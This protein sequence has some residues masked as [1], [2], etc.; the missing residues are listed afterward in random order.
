MPGHMLCRLIDAAAA[1]ARQH[2]AQLDEVDR[3]LGDADHGSN[4]LGGIRA[5]E[6]ARERLS[7]LPLGA[8]LRLAGRIVSE[9]MPGAGRFY[10]VLLEEMGGCA[11]D[12][13]VTTGDLVR[14]VEAGVAGVRRAGAAAPG[15]KTMLDV[16][17]PVAD[18]LRIAHDAGDDHLLGTRALAAAAAGLHRTSRCLA[19]KGRAAAR[20]EE[21]LG[22]LDPGACSCA[23]MIGAVIAT[24]EQ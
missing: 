2:A 3:A 21:S 12:G 17:C 5:L 15:Q 7:L 16:L 8:A 11:P 20:R 1:V 13:Q 18:A 4:L 6:A 22:H 14:M 10:G 9:R 19:T 23:L 24:L